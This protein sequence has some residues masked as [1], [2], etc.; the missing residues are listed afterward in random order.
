MHAGVDSSF[1]PPK[2]ETPV[3]FRLRVLSQS[4]TLVNASLAQL[5]ER[6]TCNKDVAG[7][8]PVRGS[9]TRPD[10]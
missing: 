4:G 7:S 3:R 10:S 2:L 1:E 9:K 6:L 8:I 5:E